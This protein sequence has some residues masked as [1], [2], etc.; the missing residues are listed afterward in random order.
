[1]F[2]VLAYFLAQGKRIAKKPKKVPEAGSLAS[3]G[4]ISANLTKSPITSSRFGAGCFTQI[5][6]LARFGW[7]IAK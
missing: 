2:V 5:N 6:G 4:A 1:M 3:W 7:R